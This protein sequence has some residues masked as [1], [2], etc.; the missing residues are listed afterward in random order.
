ML[1]RTAGGAA[2]IRAHA[3]ATGALVASLPARATALP[4]L[5]TVGPR[6]V[7]AYPRRIM[8]WNVRAHT[9]RVLRRLR[10]FPHN[11]LADGRL[12]AWNTHHAIRGV[13]LAPAG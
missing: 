10:A 8:V 9:L 13:R 4:M 12:V 1:V 6:V 5:A 3:A 7:F 11:L 2:R